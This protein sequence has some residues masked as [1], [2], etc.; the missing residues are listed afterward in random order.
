M[1]FP[2]LLSAWSAPPVAPDARFPFEP[3]APLADDQDDRTFTGSGCTVGVPSFHPDAGE[4]LSCQGMGGQGYDQTSGTPLTLDGGFT[5]GAWIRPDAV[6]LTQ[7]C[8]IAAQ[9]NTGD[10]V[11]DPYGFLLFTEA[12]EIALEVQFDNDDD[13]TLRGAALTADTWAW[14]V[15]VY[16]PGTVRFY[17]DGSRTHTVSTRSDDD[18]GEGL[19]LAYVVQRSYDFVGDVDELVVF[20]KA[21]DD[22]DVAALWGWYDDGDGDGRIMDGDCN[23]ADPSPCDTGATAATGDTGSTGGT[24]TTADTGSPPTG[25]TGATG[26]PHTGATGTAGPTG[27]SDTGTPPHT[28][29]TETGTQPLETADT[30]LGGPT[31]DDPAAAQGCRCTSASPPHL[32]GLLLWLLPALGRRRS[33]PTTSA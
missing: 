30:A 17:L 3:P 12:G 15:A 7:L 27:A 6:C 29:T 22:A 9:G 20:D 16:E 1:L 25:D 11:V 2:W 5:V 26:R 10:D 21:L 31:P 23:P 33:R 8:V 19:R 14:V 4:A 28:A 13:E 18:L 24:A 32:G